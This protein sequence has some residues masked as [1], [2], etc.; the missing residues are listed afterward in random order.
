M[1]IIGR[2][3]VEHAICDTALVIKKHGLQ[4]TLD[5][6]GIVL[7]L[8]AFVDNLISQIRPLMRA[9]QRRNF[10]RIQTP[11]RLR[12]GQEEFYNSPVRSGGATLS[13]S[14]VSAPEG[15]STSI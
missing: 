8:S 2:W 9:M 12:R 11:S 13:Q 10:K 1:A 14:V 3:P 5:L 7:T 15:A 6:L 4:V